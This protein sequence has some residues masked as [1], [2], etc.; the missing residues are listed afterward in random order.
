MSDT[1]V[2]SISSEGA[3]LLAT[4]HL[5]G[6]ALRRAER[7][8][9]RARCEMANATEALGKWMVPAASEHVGEQLNIWVGDGLLGAKRLENG[10]HEVKWRKEPG[11]RTAM[12]LG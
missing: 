5:C 12:N 8:F 4:W 7:D 1:A 11:P 9:N 6:E 2:Y 10:N 3:K